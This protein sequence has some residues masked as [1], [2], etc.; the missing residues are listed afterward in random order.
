MPGT[1]GADFLTALVVAYEIAIRVG[2]IR[3][4]ISETYHLSG[5]WAPIGGAAAAGKI[6]KCDPGILREAVGTAGG[7]GPIAPMMKVISK[8][9]MMKDG[10]G[11]GAMVGLTSILMAEAGFTGVNP[12]FPHYCRASVAPSCSTMPRRSQ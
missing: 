4:A 2:M 7:Y 12:I 9:Y 5:S 8:P 6:M 10:S 11:W 1:T 3:H